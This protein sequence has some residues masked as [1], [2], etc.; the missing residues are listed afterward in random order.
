MKKFQLLTPHVLLEYEYGKKTNSQFFG[1]HDFAVLKSLRGT[2]VLN[3]DNYVEGEN[4]PYTNNVRERSSTNIDINRINTHVWLGL[5]SGDPNTDWVAEKGED[6][7]IEWIYHPDTAKNIP[8]SLSNGNLLTGVL[9]DRVRL[10]FVSGFT[11]SEKDLGFILNVQVKDDNERRITLAHHVFDRLL[12]DRNFNPDPFLHNQKLFDTYIEFYVPSTNNMIEEWY[13]VNDEFGSEEDRKDNSLL[14]NLT[15]VGINRYQYVLFQFLTIER[16]SRVQAVMSNHPNFQEENQDFQ[17]Y[18]TIANTS[19]TLPF[20]SSEANVSVSIQESDEGDYF[21]LQGL[22]QGRAIG[23]YIQLINLRG[24]NNILIYDV[25]VLEI[26]EHSVAVQTASYTIFQTEDFNDPVLFR[27][28]IVNSD[29]VAF[30]IEVSM[31]LFDTTTSK[32]VST[33]GRIIMEENTGAVHR[34]GKFQDIIAMHPDWPNFAFQK[35]NIYNLNPAA[36]VINFPDTLNDKLVGSTIKYVHFFH[37]TYPLVLNQGSVTIDD[38]GNVSSRDD[39]NITTLFGDNSLLLKLNDG[40]TWIKLVV[41]DKTNQY[42]LRKSLLGTG[43][44]QLQLGGKDSGFVYDM[45]EDE[46]IRKSEGE[47]LFK[48]PSQDVDGLRKVQESNNSVQLISV[49]TIDTSIVHR[50]KFEFYDDTT[51][52]D[53]INDSETRIQELESR[54]AELGQRLVERNF[55]V[56]RLN[57]EIENLKRLGD[58]KDRRIQELELL[59]REIRGMGPDSEILFETRPNFRRIPFFGVRSNPF[60]KRERVI[61]RESQNNTLY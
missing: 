9:Y 28:V 57:R 52:A 19:S 40:T 8:H 54:R 50:G 32:Q 11:F 46:A 15:D 25:R 61:E 60:D 4:D 16:K 55:E 45:I 59:I 31:R 30:E 48:I 37:D 27:P 41:Y 18:H 12:H 7:E 10:H 6:Q 43:K 24:E 29:S 35:Q 39:V 5:D 44:Y 21:E 42:F 20:T 36:Q 2:Q 22:H 49:S 51:I 13:R 1:V 58:I 34:Y 3:P 23:D 47:L 17:F 53:I 14:H 56:G 38:E 33:T 26:D